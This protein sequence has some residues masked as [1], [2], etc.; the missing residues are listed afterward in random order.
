MSDAAMATH[1]ITR[2]QS[3]E[4][5]IELLKSE[6][7]SFMSLWR[8][9]SDYHLAHR[10]RFLVS[11]RNKGHKRN[12]KQINNASRRAIRTLASGMM[13]GITSPA[14]PWFKLALGNQLGLMEEPGV[15]DW[16]LNVERILREIFNQSNTYNTLH[17]VYQEL[18]VFGTGSIGVYKDY[19]NVIRCKQYTVGSYFLALNGV[20][21]VDSWAREY[22]QTAGQLVKEFG[23]KNCSLSVQKQWDTGNTEAWVDVCHL[24]EPN[25]DRDRQNPLARNKMF[26]SVYFEKGASKLDNKFLRESGFDGFPIMAPRWE[27][28]GE[29]IYGVACPGTDAIGDTKALQLSETQLYEGIEKRNDPHMVAPTSMRNVLV[30]GLPAGEVSFYDGVGGEGLKPA[31]QFDPKIGDHQQ[32]IL[33][34]EDRIDKAFYVDLFLMLANSDRRQKGFHVEPL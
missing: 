24:I 6:R 19:K 14:R 21:E 31:Y 9:L 16:L 18:G 1:S 23:Y 28:T 22:Q 33:R 27:V 20:D 13:A 7:S 12:T 26:R 2:K 11:D 30:K 29:D 4:K 34:V 10:G 32:D 5:R 17:A 25:D 8:E 3:Y 15:K